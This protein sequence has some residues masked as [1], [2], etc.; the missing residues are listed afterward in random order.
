MGT[1][2][3]SRVP[4]MAQGPQARCARWGQNRVDQGGLLGRKTAQVYLLQ[5]GL[6]FPLKPCLSH[7]LEVLAQTLC[8]PDDSRAKWHRCH[9][10]ADSPA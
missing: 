2:V 8:H 10:Q 1:T 7:P 4:S 3:G 9:L 5:Q 6:G